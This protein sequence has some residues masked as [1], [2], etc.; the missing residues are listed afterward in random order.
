[1]GKTQI[2][3]DKKWKKKNLLASRLKK[4]LKILEMK[5]KKSFKRLKLKKVKLTLNKFI[6]K[7]TIL[8]NNAWKGVNKKML[9]HTRNEN[10]LRI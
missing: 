6:F 9:V 7:P 2:Y 1:M 10:G 4:N 5:K 3:R 8:K